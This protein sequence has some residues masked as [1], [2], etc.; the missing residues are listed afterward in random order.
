[1][2]PNVLR[3]CEVC[4]AMAE[5][6]WA[7]VSEPHILPLHDPDRGEERSDEE[8]LSHRKSPASV[9]FF[10]V[11]LRFTGKFRLTSVGWC[12]VSLFSLFCFDCSFSVKR[13]EQG[14]IFGVS[15]KGGS[16]ILGNVFGVKEARRSRIWAERSVVFYTVLAEVPFLPPCIQLFCGIINLHDSFLKA[17]LQIWYFL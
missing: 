13:S 5:Q 15:P 8:F 17:I 2:S 6:I 14:R 9:V 7:S 10:Y 11:H 4:G 12:E 16:K 1:M 3:I